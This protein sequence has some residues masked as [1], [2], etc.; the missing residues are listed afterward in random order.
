[1]TYPRAWAAV[2]AW[3]LVLTAPSPA[4]SQWTLSAGV[5]SSRFSGGAAA[6]GTDRSLLPYRPTM[7]EVGV[8]QGGSRFGGELRLHYASSSLA[9][10]GED[11][12][13]AIKDAMTV[14]GIAPAISLP[15]S[16]LGPAG[17]LRVSAGPLVEVWNMPDLGSNWRVGVAASIS[18]EVPFGGRWSGTARLGGAVSPSPFDREDLEPPLEPRTLWRREAAANLQ[19]RL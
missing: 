5:R 18:L 7:I 19:Y 14:Y 16:H 6:P 15:V 10:E 17:L 11:A 13:A 2:L 12:V 9:L 1:M 4:S 8:A 3:L